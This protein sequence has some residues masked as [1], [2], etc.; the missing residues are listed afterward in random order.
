MASSALLEADIEQERRR[1]AALMGE[2][3]ERKLGAKRLSGSVMDAFEQLREDKAIMKE[4]GGDSEAEE[5]VSASYFRLRNRLSSRTMQRV[6]GERSDSVGG[7]M[8]KAREKHIFVLSNAGK[9][10][11][12]RYGD[13]SHLSSLFGMLQAILSRTDDKLRSVRAGQHEIVFLVRNPL[14]LISVTKSGEPTEYIEKQL[15]YIHG[16]ILFH[17]TAKSLNDIFRR[18]ASYDLRGLLG[19]T[20]GFES[21]LKMSHDT[22]SVMFEAPRSLRLSTDVRSA[23][24]DV[25]LSVKQTNLIYA[26]LLADSAL[27]TLVSPK[28][29]PMANSDLLLLINFVN[30]TQQLRS[31]ETW[32]PLCLPGFNDQGFL[33]A[34]AAFISTNVSLFLIS[35]ENTLE[36][37]HYSSEC[38]NKIAS[39]LGRMGTLDA[40]EKALLKPLYGPPDFVSAG[41]ASET[42][43]THT[44]APPQ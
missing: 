39:E 41:G 28:K 1:Q 42:F 34:Y 9:P 29:H 14:F 20:A 16:Y 13:E 27:V 24:T 33:N 2:E 22:S 30:S 40:I 23:A 15:S 44:R 36:Q 4:K 35:A 43:A 12:S 11:Y 31:Q 32:T 18:K 8:W 37:F 10:V 21:L 38:K 3:E 19:G 26:V 25:L 17:M 5:G 6:R 7:E